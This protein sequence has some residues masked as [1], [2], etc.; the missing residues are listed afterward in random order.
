[1]KNA[2]LK[3]RK[4][5]RKRR[6]KILKNCG[7][8]ILCGLCFAGAYNFDKPVAYY[9]EKLYL[10]GQYENAAKTYET[11][12]VLKPDNPDY[13]LKAL[14]A[15]AKTPFTYSVQNKFLKAAQK[16]DGSEAERFAT[17]TLERFR[18]EIFYKYGTGYVTECLYN[19]I[20][21]HWNKAEFPIKYFIGAKNPAPDY[22]KSVAA[23]SFGDWQRES[24]EFLTFVPVSSPEEADI[25]LYFSD[26]AT[27]ITPDENDE[28]KAAVTNPE[29]GENNTLKKMK[30][31][32]LIK[33]YEGRL[34][35]PSELKI[36][37]SHEIGHALGLWGHTKDNSTIMY[38]SR[39]NPHSYYSDR[40]DT[41]LNDKDIAT[42][43]LLY[44]LAPDVTN[45][46][47]NK[48]QFISPDALFGNLSV[49]T[50]IQTTGESSVDKTATVNLAISFSN[51]HEYIKSN[52]IINNILPEL[53][54]N[55]LKG[56][57][58]SVLAH[59]HSKTKNFE[60]ALIEAKKSVIF[61]PV[62]ANYVVLGRVY[63]LKND[64][65][66]AEKFY[67]EAFRLDGTNIQA[68]FGLADSYIKQFRFLAARNVLKELVANNPGAQN[69][70]NYKYYGLITF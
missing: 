68:G 52:E 55:K 31:D 59:N 12:S 1:M 65:G 51:N 16:A 27:D 48:E 14:K 62:S 2:D 60:Q 70:P 53:N 18:S 57:A 38:Y 13:E 32:V 35:P 69:D 41:S 20:V 11:L 7:L 34:F 66:N 43:K 61:D 54:D 28:Y 64:Y 30:I 29:I 21:M 24:G 40:I 5:K 50:E 23:S 46:P 67:K 26:N 4:L 49:S 37:L 3:S 44:A 25:V 15:S 39:N 22:Y 10:S 6:K 47:G 56:A 36:I 45:N 19:G 42:I 63:F 58:F 9:A 8:V 17:E 33:D